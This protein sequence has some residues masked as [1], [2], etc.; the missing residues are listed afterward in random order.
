[1]GLLICYWF[2]SLVFTVVTEGFTVHGSA[3][4]LSVQLGA[5][6]TLPCSVDTP[7]PLSELEVEWMRAESG[8]LVHLFQEGQSRP[9]FQN[10]SYSSRAEFFTEEIPKGN[11]SL[12]LINVTTEDMGV[13]RCAVHTD[14]ESSETNLEIHI[15]WLVVTGASEPV[16]AFDGEDVILNCSVDTHAPVE[17]LE[18]EWVKMDQ[19]GL[20][21]LFQE[22]Q[23]Q[24]EFQHERFRGR[25]EFFTEEIQKGNFSLKLRGVRTEDRGEYMCK[26][27]TDTDSVSAKAR[28]QGF[29]SLHISVLVLSIAAPIAACVCFCPLKALLE[30]DEDKFYCFCIFLPCGLICAAFIIWGI[31]EGSVAEV[32][33]CTAINLMRV[34][35]LRKVADKWRWSIP[36]SRTCKHCAPIEHFIILTGVNSDVLWKIYKE[37]TPDTGYEI[38]GL[39]IFVIMVLLSFPAVFW[40]K[41]HRFF[42]GALVVIN[43]METWFLGFTFGIISPEYF[44][45]SGIGAV[46]VTMCVILK[47]KKHWDQGWDWYS[48]WYSDWDWDSDWRT[49]PNSAVSDQQAKKDLWKKIFLVGFFLLTLISSFIY[50]DIILE[51]HKERDAW[52]CLMAL[53][54]IL[55]VTAVFDCRRDLPRREYTFWYAFGALALPIVNGVAVAVS[56]IQKATKGERTVEDLR[57]IVVPFE[58]IFLTC[59]IGLKVY[60]Y[61]REKDGKIKKGM[62]LI[63]QRGQTQRHDPA[64]SAQNQESQ[65]E[66]EMAPSS[67]PQSNMNNSQEE[68]KGSPSEM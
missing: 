2:L 22:G 19:E 24:P 27:H 46:G 37:H 12:L 23:N 54:Y 29:S 38:T 67:E 4:P 1:M 28:L 66:H 65:E 9:E 40:H 10:P 64:S 44:V 33:T 32:N 7:L 56:V 68:A 53:L 14:L 59:W 3:V 48:D 17:E 36:F 21:L 16:L 6:V 47:K 30:Y 55:A 60:V 25:A 31:M 11:F 45:L 15:E 5:S 18:V 61:C 43:V 26:V 34:L 13:Y 51:K 42:F 50:L 63:F 49:P 39:C 57:V 58:C 62:R 41:G 35:M 52:M 8:T 20:V